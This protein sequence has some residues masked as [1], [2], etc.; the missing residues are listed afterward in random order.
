MAGNAGELPYTRSIRR[1][2]LH[3]PLPITDSYSYQNYQRQRQLT[4]GDLLLENRIV[5]LQGEIYTA[6]PTKW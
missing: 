1:M 5:F 2:S 4:L 3:L 6:T